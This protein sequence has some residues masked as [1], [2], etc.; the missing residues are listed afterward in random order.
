MVTLAFT[1]PRGRWDPLPCLPK[2]CVELELSSVFW[3]LPAS[4][5]STMSPKIKV[6]THTLQQVPFADVLK[7][8]E[9]E[10]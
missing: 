9:A 1:A 4:R 7:A 5:I 6:G 8:I 3:G 10:D 2:F